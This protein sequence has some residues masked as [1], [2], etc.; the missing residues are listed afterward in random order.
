MGFFSIEYNG[1]YLDL[2]LLFERFIV[3]IVVRSK[4]LRTFCLDH[5]FLYHLSS[6]GKL[7]T[8]SFINS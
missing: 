2:Q 6:D 5:C 4:G 3:I 8:E 7:S 1:Y